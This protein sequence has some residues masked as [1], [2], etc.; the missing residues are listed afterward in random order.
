MAL[1]Q[2]YDEEHVCCEKEC[3]RFG[4]VVALC[5]DTWPMVFT[6]RVRSQQLHSPTQADMKRAKR[7]TRFSNKVAQTEENRFPATGD[8][9]AEVAKSLGRARVLV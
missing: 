9:S 8:V 2:R 6:V 1:P 5:D 4:Q 3:K 7:V